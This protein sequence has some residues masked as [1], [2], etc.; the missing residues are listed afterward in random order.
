MKGFVSLTQLA[1]AFGKYIIGYRPDDD[2]WSP[3][4]QEAHDFVLYDR[5]YDFEEKPSVEKRLR[6]YQIDS[7]RISED[8][9]N[10]NGPYTCSFFGKTIEDALETVD[11]ELK[12][13]KNKKA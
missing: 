13:A 3:E 7:I 1:I 4:D 9:F 8:G 6:D 10:L 2:G 11:R 12:N 5:V